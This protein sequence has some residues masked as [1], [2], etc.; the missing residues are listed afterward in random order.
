MDRPNFFL[1]L[2]LDFD[3]PEQDAKVIEE[4]IKKKMSEWSQDRAHPTKGHRAMQYMALESK[5]REVMI[6]AAARNQEASGEATMKLKNDVVKLIKHVANKGS[7]PESTIKKMS[8][9]RGVSVQQIK[10]WIPQNVQIINDATQA[11]ANKTYKNAVKLKKVS[12]YTDKTLYEFLDLTP[13]HTCQELRA[14]ANE[15]LVKS[16][17]TNNTAGV[18]VS[19]V[20]LDIFKD[21]QAKDEYDQY[22]RFQ[23][24]EKAFELLDLYDDNQARPADVVRGTIKQMMSCGFTFNEAVDQFKAYCSKKRYAYVMPSEWGEGEAVNLITCGFCYQICDSTVKVCTACGQSLYIKCPKC[25]A[26]NDSSS[27]ACKDCGYLFKN[28]WQ[29]KQKCIDAAKLIEVL[30]LDGAQSALQ[31]AARLWP[32]C[33]DISNV[34]A[35]LQAKQEIVGN[36]MKNIS[37][38]MQAEYYQAAEDEL[39]Q[40]KRKMPRYS[41]ASLERTIATKLK[42]AAE[43]VAKAKSST[44]DD[45][46]IQYCAKALEICKDLTEA[47][48][49]LEKYPPLPPIDLQLSQVNGINV[50]RWKPSSSRGTVIY[51]V[52]RKENMVPANEKDGQCLVET[53]NLIYE[54]K[55]VE[56][57]LS[58]YY[59]VYAVRGGI[60]SAPLSLKSPVVQYKEVQKLSVL[61]GE[62]NAQLTW[63][64]DQAASHVE[65]WRK[66]GSIPIQSGDGIKLSGVS[67]NGVMDTNLENNQSY[68]YLVVTVYAT[69]NGPLYTKG[70]SCDCVPMT[71]PDPVRNVTAQTVAPGHFQ[72]KW[73]RIKDRVQ[74]YYAVQMIEGNAGDV[75]PLR[76][77]EEN[78]KRIHLTDLRPDGCAFRL[79]LDDIVYVYP[80]TVINNMGVIGE[81]TRIAGVKDFD[82][83]QYQARGNQVH[84]QFNWPQKVKRALILFSTQAYPKSPGDKASRI[85]ISREFYAHRGGASIDIDKEDYFFTIFA[86]YGEEGNSIYSSGTKLLVRNAPLLDITYT[87]KPDKSLFG[88]ISGITVDL[89]TTQKLSNSPEICVVRKANV[90]P[91]NRND[92]EVVHVLKDAFANGATT[93]V[94]IKDNIVAKRTFYR[95]FFADDASYES[96]N[97]IAPNAQSLV[98]TK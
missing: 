59:V 98:I 18:E 89:R 69:A 96:Y 56:S 29:A 86:D 15:I 4:R 8:K 74:V 77:I 3:P 78:L 12:N 38:F 54:D 45:E 25:K 85:T 71:Y 13:N 10:R 35:E 84:L 88:K 36:H 42:A 40:L 70:V 64:P 65:V 27:K 24:L 17:N 41:D 19:G 9:S 2:E 32:G 50:L 33:P 94:S 66:K 57:C 43:W 81:C 16:R 61:T 37:K 67:L 47:R 75:K 5:M 60:V 48:A 83:L 52:V 21:E 46:I 58:Y 90:L 23:L 26:E 31:E 6:D 39:R 91:L 34:R 76:E 51:K 63:D 68:G 55:N 28:M 97:L 79:S 53:S 49:I 73:G 87:I 30:E 92:G 44:L 93:K 11:A 62:S 95:L 80:V 20:C 72:L 14:K 1:V 7:I 82:N 22:L